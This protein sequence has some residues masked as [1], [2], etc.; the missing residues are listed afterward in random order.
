MVD[1]QTPSITVW[2]LLEVEYVERAHVVGA[3][4][5]TLDQPFLV[6][7]TPAQLRDPEDPT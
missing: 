2:E 3:D 7:L 5:L 1:P 6:E 4:T